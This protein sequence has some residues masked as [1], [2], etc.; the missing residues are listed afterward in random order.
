MASVGTAAPR[1]LS[2]TPAAPPNL[3]ACPCLAVWFHG[4]PG[5]LG[6]GAGQLPRALTGAECGPAVTGPWP[7]CG[8][9]PH[10]AS[11]SRVLRTSVQPWDS[12]AGLGVQ[13]SALTRSTDIR[14]PPSW[15]ATCPTR[16]PWRPRQWARLLAWAAGTQ[17]GS[18]LPSPFGTFLLT[19]SQLLPALALPGSLPAGPSQ[20]GVLGST[21]CGRLDN[22]TGAWTR[23][24]DTLAA[25]RGRLR[26]A[27]PRPAAAA[28]STESLF[29]GLAR[30]AR[31]RLPR[32]A[33]A[34]APGRREAEHAAGT[35]RVTASLPYL[36]PVRRAPAP[37]WTEMVAFHRT[38]AGQLLPGHRPLWALTGTTMLGGTWGLQE[39]ALEGSVAVSRKAKPR[40]AVRLRSSALGSPPS[41]S[42]AVGPHRL[43]CP[44]SQQHYLGQPQRRGSPSVRPLTKGYTDPSRGWF[45][46]EKASGA[47]RRSVVG[48][49]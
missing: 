22:S 12:Y 19:A 11:P 27:S 34:R 49:L 39:A 24:G 44:G 38:A 2:P 28:R 36:P 26:D 13:S 42:A 35:Q 21:A 7:L 30:A 48:D 9:R 17:T 6:S 29:M 10:L 5:L 25:V 1:E 46:H 18:G 23:S 3:W 32:Q 15:R 41:G 47:D 20:A 31:P 40:V 4:T 14:S 33:L 43:W 37:L 16:S 8:S 45:G